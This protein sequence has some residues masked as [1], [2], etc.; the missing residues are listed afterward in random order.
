MIVNINGLSSPITPF[1]G[2][3]YSVELMANESDLFWTV[4]YTTKMVTFELHTY[5]TGWIAL[6]IS[7]GNI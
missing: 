2:Y 4:D 3:T 5:T 7:P 6:G 1:A